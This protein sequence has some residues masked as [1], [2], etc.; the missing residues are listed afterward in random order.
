MS[1]VISADALGLALQARRPRVPCTRRAEPA[2]AL[3][4][5]ALL[6]KAPSAHEAARGGLA[7]PCPALPCPGGDA[8]GA[9]HRLVLAPG[10]GSR[11]SHTACSWEFESWTRTFQ[12]S[13][14]VLEAFVVKSNVLTAVPTFLLLFFSLD[15]LRGRGRLRKGAGRAERR[16]AWPQRAALAAVVGGALDPHSLQGRQ[17]SGKEDPRSA[18]SKSERSGIWGARSCQSGGG[19]QH[20]DLQMGGPGQ[21]PRVLMLMAP[22]AEGLAACW[23]SLDRPL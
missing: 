1:P 15:V 13:D 9:G 17:R 8:A 22:R 5:P 2:E 3:G 18:G 20:G 12:L 4:V 19:P 6:R 11:S 10:L 23:T 16:S 21:T 14:Q 7:L